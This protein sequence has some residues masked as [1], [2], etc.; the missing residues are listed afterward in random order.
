MEM[1]VKKEKNEMSFKAKMAELEI[2]KEAEKNQSAMYQ[3]LLEL[4]AKK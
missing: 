4:V 1:E 3:L 2:R